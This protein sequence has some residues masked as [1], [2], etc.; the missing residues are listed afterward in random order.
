MAVGRNWVTEYDWL[1]GLVLGHG[2]NLTAVDAHAIDI[3]FDLLLWHSPQPC[4]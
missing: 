2:D 3:H 1:N 4:G